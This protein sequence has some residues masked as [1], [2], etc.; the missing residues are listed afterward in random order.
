MN[1]LITII[2]FWITRIFSH[3]TLLSKSWHN[4][5]INAPEVYKLRRERKKYHF[6]NGINTPIVASFLMLLIL[7]CI[8]L[9]CLLTWD[10]TG[11][12]LSFL[13]FIKLEKDNAKQL[14]SDSLMAT[15][16][17]SA[18]S[19]VVIN[20]LFDKVKDVTH[21]TYQTLF[22]ATRLYFV[23]SF[24]LMG[25]L[26]MVI[27]NLLKHTPS[28]DTLGNMALWSVYLSIGIVIVI[29]LLFFRVLR[30]LNP[31]SVAS[32]SKNYLLNAA[33]FHR[34]DERLFEECNNEL[35]NIFQSRDFIKQTPFQF[36][37]DT[38]ELIFV[39][40][41]N[42]SEGVLYDLH[43][44]IIN[45][46]LNE[47]KRKGGDNI[48]YFPVRYS[49]FLN[50]NHKIIAIGEPISFGNFLLLVLPFSIWLKRSKKD[51]GSLVEE[52][53]KMSD[54]LIQSAARGDVEAL[55]KQLSNIN[56]LYNIYY[57]PK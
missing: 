53:M 16:T 6:A 49:E 10:F 7:S 35:Q 38:N 25:F 52:K 54:S 4:I 45:R 20:F 34:M 55:K 57:E 44:P 43:L 56:D 12:P 47:I 9:S 41:K 48:S 22:R 28:D 18:L 1:R 26:T 14:I 29:L 30:F 32:L 50:A 3:Q 23:L 31:Q 19:F 8:S 40:L 24:V 13:N 39:S 21:E 51:E 15:A 5:K 46:L 11:S 33:K 2:I 37:S 36:Q 42:R 27:L 17:I